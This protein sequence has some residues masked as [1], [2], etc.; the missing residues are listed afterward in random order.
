MKEA[1][2]LEIFANC[3]AQTPV[4]SDNLIAAQTSFS[5]KERFFFFLQIDLRN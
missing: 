4:Y 3:D 1:S 5:A 2:F